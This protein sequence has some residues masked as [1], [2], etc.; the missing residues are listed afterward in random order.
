[1]KERYFYTAHYINRYT[2]GPTFNRSDPDD[3]WFS[4]KSLERA[5]ELAERYRDLDSQTDKVITTY[6]VEYVD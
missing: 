4:I 2:S 6:G 1:M 5:K 3:N